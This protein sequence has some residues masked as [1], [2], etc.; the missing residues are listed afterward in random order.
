MTLSHPAFSLVPHLQIDGVSTEQS[1]QF[2][3]LILL[4]FYSRFLVPRAS[5]G[6]AHL[7]YQNRA[8]F[9][10]DYVKAV[11]TAIRLVWELEE[12][13]HLVTF[14]EAFRAAD[15]KFQTTVNRAE[16]MANQWDYP[17]D[18]YHGLAEIPDLDVYRV[19]A[20]ERNLDIDD[21][22]VNFMEG[23]FARE[24][25]FHN[26]SEEFQAWHREPYAADVL[27]VSAFVKHPQKL[28]ADWS[29]AEEA[30]PAPQDN[31]GADGLLQEDAGSP[32]EDQVEEQDELS[33][34]DLNDPGAISDELESEEE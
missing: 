32:V 3:F 25:F 20:E 28:E 11:D 8:Q 22:W 29:Y 7:Q 26:H 13:Q 24:I 16:S 21:H 23:V 19:L 9:K 17:A 30:A 14:W 5:L 34:K 27:H 12:G 33:P 18:L 4:I 31:G 10:G 1:L 6:S 15:S 2:C